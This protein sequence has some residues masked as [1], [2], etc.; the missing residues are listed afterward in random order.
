MSD[1]PLVQHADD[2]YEAVRALNHGTFRTIPAP[3]A[4]SLLGNLNNVGYGIS[5][6]TEQIATGL[7]GSLTE[8]DVYDNNRDPAESVATAASLL[9]SAAVHAKEIG[10]LLSEAQ[11]AINLQGYNI[12]GDGDDGATDVE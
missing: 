12:K 5:Q 3:L 2:A 6:L 8:Y 4:Y 1:D 7:E 10:R 9:R 11:T